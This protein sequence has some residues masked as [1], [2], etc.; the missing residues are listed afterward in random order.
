MALSESSIVDDLAALTEKAAL[1]DA[2]AQFALAQALQA[3][4][5]GAAPNL[6]QAI[7]WYF[8]AASRDHV[9]AQ[10]NLGLLLLD[11][12]AKAGVKRNPK[13]AFAWLTKA[14]N[15]GNAA[16]QHRLGLMLLAGDGTEKNARA[17]IDWLERAALE[18][19]ADAQFALGYRLV[20]GQ[21]VEKDT[22]RGHQCLLMATQQDHGDAMYHLGLLL[23]HGAGFDAPNVPLAARMYTRAVAKHGHRVAAHDLAILHATGRGVER[24][25]ELAEELLEYSISAGED[26]S[27]YDL[28]LL[29]THDGPQQDLPAAVMWATLAVKHNPASAGTRL[30]Q[31]LAKIATPAQIAEGRQR[32]DAWRRTPKGLTILTVGGDANEFA[33][34]SFASD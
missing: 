29:L 14:A 12:V 3:G 13:Q 7:N 26:K 33:N 31:A 20:T 24:D 1:G 22:A 6:P 17:G 8:K 15:A 32:A 28:G 5:D 16:A 10:L 25:M 30:L 18:N 9:A 34:L 19:N 27:M 11:D 4:S 2:E 21:D 23:E